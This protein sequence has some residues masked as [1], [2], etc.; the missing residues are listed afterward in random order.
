MC[1]C[2]LPFAFIISFLE[3]RNPMLHKKFN[4][5]AQVVGYAAIG[6]LALYGLLNLLGSTPAL[7]TASAALGLKAVEMPVIPS[8]FNYQGLL[9]NPDGSLTTGA[10]TITAK[11]YDAPADGSALY[12]ETFTP[13]TVRDG[14]FNIV[15]GDDPQGQDLQSVFSTT[16]RY[17]GI[18]LVG[19]GAELIP[20]Q[21]L[22]G[23][24]WALYATNADNATN[25]GNAT[26]A[27]NADNADLLDGQHADTL[28]PL[29][30]VVAFAGSTPPAGWLLCDGSAVTRTQYSAL[31]AAIGTAHG[32]GD[33]TTTFNLPDYRGRFLRGVDGGAGIDPD[34]SSRTEMN[35]GGNTGDQVGSVQDDAFE[36]HTH[37]VE[38]YSGI[39]QN[40]IGSG[41]STRVWEGNIS[42]E[43]G[44]TGGS[45]TRPFN[46]YVNWII[47][48]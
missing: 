20:R 39:A 1:S 16:P 44:V 35:P 31:F 33:G 37:T 12:T 15:L 7:A 25:A 3:R 29:G 26:N 4:S 41:G 10:Y 9:R 6:L 47:K 17:I 23:V 30:T 18:T 27:A 11:I 36:S 5:I 45:E 21:R 38:R 32:S 24:P 48:Y 43:T 22:H 2:V 34:R 46:A 8:T 13:V 19:Q 14:L 40:A 42:F 28:V